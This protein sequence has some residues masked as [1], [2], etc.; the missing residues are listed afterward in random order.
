MLYDCESWVCWQL[1]NSSWVF[2]GFS[3]GS[4]APVGWQS[5]SKSIISLLTKV[6]SGN[7]SLLL[8]REMS[9]MAAQAKRYQESKNHHFKAYPLPC[10]DLGLTAQTGKSMPFTVSVLSQSNSRGE[11]HQKG[12]KR[13]FQLR[14]SYLLGGPLATCSEL[15]PI[16]FHE[17]S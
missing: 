11:G 9:A 2:V 10:F 14:A 1:P 15:A 7:T 8:L 5:R 6:S 12:V 3:P 17:G 4:S 13:F 16:Y